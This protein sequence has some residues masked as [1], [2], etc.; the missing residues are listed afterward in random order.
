M[1]DADQRLTICSWCRE[2][3]SQEEQ[4]RIDAKSGILIKGLMHE[5]CFKAVYK[6]E[7]IHGGC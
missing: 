1:N 6:E 3:I 7:S 2:P 5:V 4:E